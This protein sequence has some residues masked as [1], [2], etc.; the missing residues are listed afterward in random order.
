MVDV[1]GTRLGRYEIRERLGKGGMAAVYKGW[2]TNLDRWVAVKVLH[3]YLAEESGFKQRFEREA[4]VVASLNH[5]NI[6]Q[7][8]DFNVEDRAGQPV[9][10][11]VMTYITGTSLKALMDEKHQRGERLSMAEIE[12]VMRGVCNALAYAH[13][14]GMVHRDVTPG[15]ILFNDHGQA[16]LADFGIARLVTAGRLTETGATTGTPMYMPP[17]QGVGQGGDHRS[18]IYSLGV[19]L[20]EMLTGQAPYSADSAV[21]I[22]MKHINEPVPSVLAQNADLPVALEAVVMQALSKDPDGRY[23]SAQA[24]L[25]DFLHAVHGGS[26]TATMPSS[27]PPV[28]IRLKG[29]SAPGPKIPWMAVFAGLGLIAVVLLFA[30]AT[31]PATSPPNTQALGNPEPRNAATKVSSVPAMTEGPLVFK[32]DFGPDRGDLIWPVTS[33]DPQVTRKIENGVYH[34]RL[35]QSATALST[36]FDPEHVYPAGFVYEGDFTILNN[37]QPDSATGIIFRYLSD[38][39]YYVF[40]INGMGQVSIWLRAD[41]QWVELRHAPGNWTHVDGANS[42]GQANHLKLIDNGSQIL[43]YVNGIQ[44]IDVTSEPV[45]SA[46][47]IGIYVATTSSSRIPNPIADVQVDNFSADYYAPATQSAPGTPPATQSGF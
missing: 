23:Q 7:V 27:T 2:D 21:G 11:M 15:N 10:Y 43:V 45:V 5:P 39:K 41:G 13:E 12:N 26:V 34:I 1:L 42:A 3:D 20:Y 32:D 29:V 30:I 4:K 6:V 47:S 22:I 44:A 16:V 14:R 33:D 36:V 18:D 46:G 8:Y 25:D 37:S 35:T 28:T 31:R 40:G 38:D 19:I 17:E 9:Y 24:L